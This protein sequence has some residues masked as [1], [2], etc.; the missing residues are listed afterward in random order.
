MLINLKHISRK[1]I[2][3]IYFL[4]FFY[5]IKL[6]NIYFY[7]LDNYSKFVYF[8]LQYWSFGHFSFNIFVIRIFCKEILWW[9]L[10]VQININVQNEYENVTNLITIISKSLKY[11]ENIKIS[12]QFSI[13]THLVLIIINVC[14]FL[15]WGRNGNLIFNENF[16]WFH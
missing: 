13:I 1:I 2:T 3:Y 14:L 8:L 12:L 15:K 16:Q 5:N 4:Y 11:K 6:D 9:K 7:I 10:Y